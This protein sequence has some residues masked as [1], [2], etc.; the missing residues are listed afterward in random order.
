MVYCLAL[1]KNLILYTTKDGYIYINY[2]D[3]NIYQGK[4]IFLM[5]KLS[6]SRRN[7]GWSLFSINCTGR[8]NSYAYTVIYHYTS[9]SKVLSANSRPPD[10]NRNKQKEWTRGLRI[11]RKVFFKIKIATSRGESNV[12]MWKEMGRWI[13]I[14]ERID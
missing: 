7:H 10:I 1:C 12:P 14:L 8:K 4:T 11:T 13:M 3:S 6:D 2:K 9:S 5:R